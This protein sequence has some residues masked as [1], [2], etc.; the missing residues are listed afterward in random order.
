MSSS[1]L[2][3]LGGCLA[4]DSASSTGT[5]SEDELV[6]AGCAAELRDGPGALSCRRASVEESAVA[7]GP[8]FE[9][10]LGELVRLVRPASPEVLGV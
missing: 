6:V 4:N 7:W 3:S 8:L 5:A 2:V 1:S 9:A 10:E